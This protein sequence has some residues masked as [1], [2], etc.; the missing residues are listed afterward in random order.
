M[1]F[2]TYLIKNKFKVCEEDENSIF[3][4]QTRMRDSKDEPHYTITGLSYISQG[5]MKRIRAMYTYLFE[6]QDV[7]YDQFFDMVKEMPKFVKLLKR[8]PESSFEET[9]NDLMD[10][11]PI[12]F[13]EVIN[14][15]QGETFDKTDNGRTL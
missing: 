3:A 14:D 8:Y 4:Y 15:R 10:N 7:T 12:C 1:D 13:A 2:K 9:M 6:F 11:G 5:D